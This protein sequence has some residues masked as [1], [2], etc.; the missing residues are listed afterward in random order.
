MAI[1]NRQ[2]GWSQKS[3]LLWDISKQLEKLIQ[4]ASNVSI[5]SS[6]WIF[7]SS[8]VSVFPE[9]SNGYTLY[10]GGWTNYDDGQTTD[11]ISFD[12]S[13][14]SNGISDTKFILSTNGYLFGAD[15]EFG[16]FANA[17]D[18]YL[19]PGGPLDDGDTQ[20]FWYKNTGNDSKWKTSVLV[21]CGHYENETVPYSYILNIYR[22]SQ[23]QY[24][25]TCCKINVGGD[26]GP[27]GVIESS[28]TA[29]Q[30]WQSDLNGITWSYLG[31]GSII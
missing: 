28:S 12:R 1:P 13:F 23:Y 4:V 15:T 24:I 25:E 10:T 14:W 3:N 30:V 31:F 5:D 27:N 18:L 20:N 2:I 26:A 29:T 21:Y 22:D 6:P 8:E 11:K 16:I 17:Q 19:T 7:V 9:N